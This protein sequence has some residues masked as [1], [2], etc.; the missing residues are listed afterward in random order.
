MLNKR[1]IKRLKDIPWFEESCITR[2]DLANQ[3]KEKLLEMVSQPRPN[4]KHPLGQILSNYT[5]PKSH[6]YDPVFDKKIRRLAPHWFYS[7]NARKKKQLLEMVNEPRPNQKTHPLGVALSNYTIPKSASYDPVFDK[8]IRRLA[9]HWFNKADYKKAKLLEMVN[10]PR[11]HW[12]THPLGRFL[13]LYTNP[14]S[15]AYDP[16]FD[17]KIK[18]LAPHWFKNQSDVVA[19]KKNGLLEMARNGE[20]KPHHTKHPLGNALKHYTHPKDRCYDPEFDKEIRKLAPHWFKYAKQ[21]K[22]QAA[23]R[24]SLV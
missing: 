17:K 16:V 4:R 2:S 12:K 8:K 19:Q 5:N 9:P 14:K 21:T 22:T 6:S 7:N 20:S 13:Y 18:R 23:Y 11:P 10:E 1:K 15:S 24:Y 3:K